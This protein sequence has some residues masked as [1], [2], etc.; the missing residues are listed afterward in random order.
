MGQTCLDLFP[1]LPH[2]LKKQSWVVGLAI[3]GRSTPILQRDSQLRLWGGYVCNAS[4]LFLCLQLFRERWR[5]T[6]VCIH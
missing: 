1:D 4:I 5:I 6:T 3:L 2:I